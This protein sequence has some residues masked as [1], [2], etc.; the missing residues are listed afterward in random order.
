MAYEGLK[1]TIPI[2][3]SSI[4]KK[5]TEGGRT[6]VHIRTIRNWDEL[7][8]PGLKKSK[9]IIKLFKKKLHRPVY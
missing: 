6:S 4:L 5:D 1:E 2:Y 3:I 8:A 7:S 9:T